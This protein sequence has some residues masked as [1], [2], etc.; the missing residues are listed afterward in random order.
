[1]DNNC[2]SSQQFDDYVLSFLDKIQKNNYHTE[3]LDISLTLTAG[4][5]RNEHEFLIP[6]AEQALQKA[7]DDNKDYSI[8]DILEE[9][10]D[11]HQKNLVWAQKLSSALS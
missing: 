6:M 4:I 1:M 10:I 8:C 2:K 5:S 11:Q 7:K 9:D 3:Q